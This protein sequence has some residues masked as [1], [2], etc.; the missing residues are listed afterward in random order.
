MCLDVACPHFSLQV[1]S[2][3]RDSSSWA[4]HTFF[5]G[6]W[7]GEG[8][9]EVPRLQDLPYSVPGANSQDYLAQLV[10]RRATLMSSFRPRT[11]L[12]SACYKTSRGSKLSAPLRLL[13]PTPCVPSLWLTLWPWDLEAQGNHTAMLMFVLLAMQWV[14]SPLSLGKKII[15]PIFYR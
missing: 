4:S 15:R 14:I 12:F 9:G 5:A 1:C 13:K 6:G 11:D 3:G 7:G 10:N 2:V 8:W